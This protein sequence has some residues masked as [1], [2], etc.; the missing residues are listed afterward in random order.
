[1]SGTGASHMRSSFSRSNHSLIG[2]TIMLW[3]L[4]N[5]FHATDLS[6]KGSL[7][8]AQT[9]SEAYTYLNPSAAI[10]TELTAT[11]GTED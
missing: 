9:D 4:Q 10:N 6:T 7:I 8:K 5:G 3:L 11:P 2:F 1:M